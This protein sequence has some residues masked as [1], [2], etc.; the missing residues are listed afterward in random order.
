MTVSDYGR[1]GGLVINRVSFF[2]FDVWRHQCVLY[3][4][5]PGHALAG[6][7]LRIVKERYLCP[8]RKHTFFSVFFFVVIFAGIVLRWLFL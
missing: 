1:G 5:T 3:M 6:I 7:K 4:Y 8:I 2:L